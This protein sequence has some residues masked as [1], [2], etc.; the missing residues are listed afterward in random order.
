MAGKFKVVSLGKLSGG[1]LAQEEK[2][3]AGVKGGVEL[4][5]ARPTSEDELISVAKDAD[6]ILGGGRFLT[7]RVMAALPKLKI[8]QTYSVGYDTLDIDAA[9]AN[10]IIVVNNPALYWCVEEV[11]NHAIT[12]LLTSAKKLVVLNNLVK[13][14]RWGETRQVMAPMAP[15]HGQTLGI[16]GCGNIGRRVARKAPV[17][18]L[19]IL[20]Y[21]PY[22]DKTLAKE[23]GITLVK[24]LPELLRQS[25]FVTVHA[26]LNEE[27]RHLIGEKEFH[28]MKPSAYFIN[29]A[30]GAIVDEAALIKALQEKMIAGAGLDV[31][32]KEPMA[33]DN[34]LLKMDNVIVVPH[35]ASYSDAALEVQAINPAQEV[36]RVLS[37]RWPNNV[38][39][40]GVKPK[41]KLVREN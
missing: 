5:G 21:D 14:G 17:F 7:P 35:T 8:I 6:A 24:S 31:F 3:L 18:G 27:T 2:E 23:A 40:E 11:A 33:P 19:K 25:D 12:L 22:V 32:E 36:A 30:R 26:L 34:P 15:V 38:V 9:T 28:Q 13:Q 37:G 20:G 10:Q 16:I 29:T 4:V 39:N 1:S 41:V